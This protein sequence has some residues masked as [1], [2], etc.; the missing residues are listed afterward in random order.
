MR[1]AQDILIITF[2]FMDYISRIG[3]SFASFQTNWKGKFFKGMYALGNYS[4]EN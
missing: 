4:T 2:N 1:V 3:V